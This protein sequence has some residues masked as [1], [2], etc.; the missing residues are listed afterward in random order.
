[1]SKANETQIGGTHYKGFEIE[2]W[3]YTLI[4]EIP[5]GEAVIIEYLSRWRL[6]GG[7]ADLKKARHWIDK[8]IEIEEAKLR[9]QKRRT[10]Q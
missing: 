9:K 8:V 6:K 3:D 2:P 10:G 4:N 1:M 7:I 5:H